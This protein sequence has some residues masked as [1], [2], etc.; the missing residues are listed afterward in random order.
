VAV[1][2]DFNRP[3]VTIRNSLLELLRSF[4]N[5]PERELPLPGFSALGARF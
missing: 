3:R 1:R 4:D 2:G 5:D